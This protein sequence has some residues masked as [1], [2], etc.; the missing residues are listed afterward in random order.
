MGVRLKMSEVDEYIREVVEK[1]D[2]GSKLLAARTAPTLK[3]SPLVRI[4]REGMNGIAVLDIPEDCCVIVHSCTGDPKAENLKEH[5]FSLVEKLI[6]DVDLIEASSIAF[7]NV[8]DSSTG[9][10]K[11][12]E[13]IAEGLV[14][15]ANRY[16]L[17]IMN[18]ENAILGNRITK[19]ANISGTMISIMHTDTARKKFGDFV[20]AKIFDK[21]PHRFAIFHPEGKPVYINSDGVGT[22]TE[23]YERA[24]RHSLA[25]YDS[26]AM[27]LDD[28]AKL[29]AIPKVVSD[30][31]EI[32]EVIPFDFLEST[33]QEIGF[34]ELGIAYIL[35]REIVGDRLRGYDDD[36]AVYNIS[37]S[38]VSVINEERLRNPPVPREGDFLVTVR[39]KPNPRSNGIT[40]K[41][42]VMVEMFGKMWHVTEVGK[43]FLNYL[44]SPSTVLFPLFSKLL[45]EQVATSVYHI[46][47]GAYNGKLARP[48]AQHNLFAKIDNL[49]PPD[50][51]ELFFVG[52]S[53][54]TPE[55]AYG[56]WPMG[57]DGFFTTRSPV[58][59]LETVKEF[60]L[61]GRVVG[62]LETAKDGKTGAEITTFNGKRVYFNGKD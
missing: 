46:S 32:N 30:V 28:A 8:I 17:A 49:F 15:G 35:H 6:T 58:S 40:D 61:E 50:W 16:S 7:V 42:R 13:E 31:V 33:A 62:Q 9:D 14:E 12:L 34:R 60:G 27:K 21:G 45:S 20:T 10:L 22:K 3:N 26:L 55:M 54:A 44:A 18:G 53:F 48:L 43:V 29:G 52:A 51:R 24:D 38:V 2:E 25:L 39:G 41:R 57:N 23:F 1:G 5:A 11:L 36:V 56:K 4:V 19:G 37:G 47:G 59:A